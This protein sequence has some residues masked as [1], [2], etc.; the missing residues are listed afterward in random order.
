MY[1]KYNF[2]PIVII[3]FVF[4]V[5]TNSIDECDLQEPRVGIVTTT[6]QRVISRFTWTTEQIIV[7]SPE[8]TYLFL[9]LDSVHKLK[10]IGIL[11]SLCTQLLCAYVDT[12]LIQCVSFD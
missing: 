1:N 10:S 11:T 8:F 3:Q 9:I 7:T 12:G 5:G 2:K 6:L 4:V